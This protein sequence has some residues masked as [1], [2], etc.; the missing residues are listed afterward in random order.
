MGRTLH[1]KIIKTKGSF[2][3]K[4]KDALYNY[5]IA[6]NQK[7][8][9]WTCENF[10]VDPYGYYPNWD[11][12]KIS[13]IKRDE[14]YN[15]LDQRENDLIKT[16]LTRTKAI[17]R[18]KK[19]KL[20]VTFHDDGDNKIGSF[21]KV[22]GNE[23]NA[24][25]VYYALVDIST[26]IKNIEITLSDEGRFLYG[27]VVIKDGK[28]RFNLSKK[29]ENINRWLASLVDKDEYAFNTKDLPYKLIQDL[30]LVNDGYKEN[31]LEYL[32]EDLQDI[33][34]FVNQKH[35][36]IQKHNWSSYNL[37]NLWLEPQYFHRL[38][39]L[40]DFDENMTPTAKTLMAGFYGEYWKLT[41]KDA[42]RESYNM[43]SQVQGLITNLG[44]E[45]LT[46]T[47]LG[48]EEK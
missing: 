38:V 21:T 15:Y 43:L 27:D 6:I 5:S 19:E 42:E 23:M 14:V 41:D 36:D 34:D 40:K 33:A 37:S 46:H 17:A 26:Q 30:N 22:Q 44:D 16:G 13:S 39:N 12:P 31:A 18:M 20:I 10:F 25:L 29:K 35:P 8:E 48:Q 47:Y 28:V 7:P 1:Y 2:T 3:D 32:N 24:L 11:N 45:T 4:D 9:I